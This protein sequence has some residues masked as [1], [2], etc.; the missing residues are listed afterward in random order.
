MSLYGDLKPDTSKVSSDKEPALPKSSA[1]NWS[2]LTRFKPVIQRRPN[3]TKKV[4]SSR[5]V[6]KPS[7]TATVTTSNSTGSECDKQIQTFKADEETK[8]VPN[9]PDNDYRSKALPIQQSSKKGKG[10]AIRSNP[11]SLE[12]D[13]NPSFPNNYEEYKEAEKRRKEEKSLYDRGNRRSGSYDSDLDYQELSNFP[14]PASLYSSGNQIL[15]LSPQAQQ[16]QASVEH[17]SVDSS[18]TGEEAYLRRVQMSVRQN[19]MSTIAVAD[20]RLDPEQQNVVASNQSPEK[21]STVIVLTNM[22]GPGEVDDNLQGE[23][24][25][26]CK[27][28]GKVE[29]CLIFEI[30]GQE[31]RIFVRFSTLES[32]GRALADL[33]GRFFGGRVV[34][35][36]FYDEKKFDSLDLGD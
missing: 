31:V 4:V 32:A 34:S 17:P 7:I 18:E 16:N 15:D 1:A 25:E 3:P 21:L 29:R 23:T 8:L 35:A 10:T 11:L 14:P 19:P 24:A 26:E 6:S 27:K 20:Q 2:A 12:D 28:Y 30:P 13:Y 22:V 9:L 36:R 33:N 5:T